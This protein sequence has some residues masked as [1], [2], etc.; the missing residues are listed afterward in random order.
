MPHTLPGGPTITARYLGDYAGVGAAWSAVHD[1][2][3][4]IGAEVIEG[5]WDVYANDPTEVAPED[6][7][8]RIFQPVARG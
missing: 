1:Y 6:V 3:A 7:E 8:T 2:A 5:G 4:R